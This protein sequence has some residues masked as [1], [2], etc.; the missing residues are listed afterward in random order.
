MGAETDLPGVEASFE[1]I[2]PG[3]EYNVWVL[4]KP[5][6]PSGEFTGRVRLRTS[7]PKVPVV[8]LPLRGTIV[9]PA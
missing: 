8:E 7:S 9:P 4:F 1:P 5:E 2:K 6:M 3:R